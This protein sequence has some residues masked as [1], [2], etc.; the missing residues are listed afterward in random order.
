MTRWQ[1]AEHVAAID[2]SFQVV[3]RALSKVIEFVP[4][5]RERENRK[6]P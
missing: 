2:L 3:F 6:G 1:G 5:R 4:R